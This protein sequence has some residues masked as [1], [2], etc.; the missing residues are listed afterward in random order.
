[1]LELHLPLPTM[2]CVQRM[3][4]GVSIDNAMFFGEHRP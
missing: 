3:P 1:M 4:E 2:A